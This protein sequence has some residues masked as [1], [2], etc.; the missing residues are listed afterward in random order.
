MDLLVGNGMFD[1]TKV[2]LTM[3]LSSFR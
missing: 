2:F 3:N 1:F